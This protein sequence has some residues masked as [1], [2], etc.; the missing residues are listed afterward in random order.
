MHEG[1]AVHVERRHCRGRVGDVARLVVLDV[2]EQAGDGL[3]KQ[4]KR[5]R[6]HHAHGKIDDEEL[7]PKFRHLFVNLVAGSHKIEAME[8][9]MFITANNNEVP[10]PEP[11]TPMFFG[12]RTAYDVLTDMTFGWTLGRGD[13]LPGLS[14]IIAENGVGI[15]VVPVGPVVPFMVIAAGPYQT[16]GIFAMF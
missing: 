4:E 16:P 10:P 3:I 1:V 14:A 2:G 7:A 13:I 9:F 5:S 11:R 8:G 15:V 6:R 12:Y